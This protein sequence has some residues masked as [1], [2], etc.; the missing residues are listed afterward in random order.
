MTDPLDPAEL[1]REPFFQTILL[2]DK[3]IDAVGARLIVDAAAS[4]MTR[5]ESER[6]MVLMT[7]LRH[8][9]SLP[10][11]K[12][13]TLQ[14]M[15]DAV[16]EAD[17]GEVPPLE[18]VTGGPD[19]TVAELKTRMHAEIERGIDLLETAKTRLSEESSLHGARQALQEALSAWTVAEMINLRLYSE[20]FKLGG[21]SVDPEVD[22]G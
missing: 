17:P 5:S 6:S 15:L 3:P 8:R 2:T 18:A 12:P 10:D 7:P 11:W 22:R 14:N 21:K 1:Y 19:V 4:A 16:T 9:I 13:T 20:S